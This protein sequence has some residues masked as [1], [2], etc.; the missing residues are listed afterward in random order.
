[1][2]DLPRPPKLGLAIRR[3]LDP[4]HLAR[5]PVDVPPLA[6]EDDKVGLARAL[7]EQ[8]GV[9]ELGVDHVVRRRPK[10]SRPPL[11][12]LGLDALVVV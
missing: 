12:R 3:R 7:E 8:H 1:M 9:A 11:A 2:D 4:R 5:G 10:V 6:L